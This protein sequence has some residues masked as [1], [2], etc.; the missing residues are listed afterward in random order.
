MPKLYEFEHGKPPKLIKE[1]K[2][3]PSKS[4]IPDKLWQKILKE[5]YKKVCPPMKNNF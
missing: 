5:T 4:R 1:W 3:V 2:L